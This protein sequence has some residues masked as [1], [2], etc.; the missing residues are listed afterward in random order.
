MK[1]GRRCKDHK[2]KAALR[3]Y[4]NQFALAFQ[5][6]VDLL[7]LGTLYSIVKCESM[8]PG[9]GK[10]VK[11]SQTFVSTLLTVNHS[12]HSQQIFYIREFCLP[13]TDK[14]SSPILNIKYFIT[15]SVK[16]AKPPFVWKWPQVYLVIK[17]IKANF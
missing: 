6:L 9:E 17:Y 16:S 13:R 7:C 4:V 10:I 3:I 2:Q 11:S 1:L 15:G 14:F 8:K 5:H 12:C